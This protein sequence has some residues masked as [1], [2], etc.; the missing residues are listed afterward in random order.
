MNPSLKKLRANSLLEA[1][2]QLDEQ[3]H[4]K[5]FV[6]NVAAIRGRTAGLSETGLDVGL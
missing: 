1:A 5:E 2:K 4:E 6:A 3:G